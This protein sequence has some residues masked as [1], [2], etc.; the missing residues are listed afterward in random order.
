[1]NPTPEKFHFLS[2]KIRNTCNDVMWMKLE[3]IG[4]QIS[5]LFVSQFGWSVVTL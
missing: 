2:L 3:S 1:M 4:K 5:Q